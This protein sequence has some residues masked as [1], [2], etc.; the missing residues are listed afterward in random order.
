MAGLEECN[1]VAGLRQRANA[2]RKALGR[3]RDDRDVLVSVVSERSGEALGVVLGHRAAQFWRSVGERVLVE[4]VGLLSPWARRLEFCGGRC[5]DCGESG[6]AATAAATLHKN[7][8]APLNTI[9]TLPQWL[10][11]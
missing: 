3:A 1:C 10:T 5:S 2:R 9:R 4:R 8:E 7:Y 6:V 11:E